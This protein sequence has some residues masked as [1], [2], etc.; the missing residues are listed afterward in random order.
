M[1][2]HSI[3]TLCTIAALVFAT[4]AVAA[5]LSV[6]V[7]LDLKGGVGSRTHKACGLTH[8]YTLFHPGRAIALAGV[9]KPVPPRFRV[10][11][12]VKQCVH[13]TFQTIWVGSAHERADG[14]YRGAYLP[15]RRGLFFVRAYVHIGTRT[16]KSDKRYFQL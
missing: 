16:T 11:L 10:K 8:H 15:H 6:T 1:P 5:A 12:K 3:A 7:T 14:S 13:G 4:G 2:R 9:V